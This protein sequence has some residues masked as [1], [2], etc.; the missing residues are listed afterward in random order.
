[1]K[2]LFF[3]I[4]LLMASVAVFG[5]KQKPPQV[6]KSKVLLD[7]GQIDE[8]KTIID[9]AIIFEKTKDKS[10]TWY[11][12]GLIYESIALRQ[13]S[14]G[15]NRDPMAFN[16][17]IEGFSKV[18]TI[19]NQFGTFFLFSDQRL[20]NLYAYLF[21][22]AAQSYQNEEFEDAVKYFD[23]VKLIY[24]DDTLAYEYAGYAAQQ[25]DNQDIALRNFEYMADHNMASVNVHRN[26]IYIY[27]SL[28]NDTTAALKATEKA[29]QQ[30]PDDHDLKQ[31]EISMLIMTNQE[32]KAKKQLE[33]AISK[34]PDNHIYYYELGY[35]YDVSDDYENSVRYYEMSLEKNPDF[36][37]ANFNLAVK[38][39]NEGAEIEKEAQ[40]MSV[41]E[42]RK[43]GKEVEE[44]A[45]VF[46]KKSLP[47]FE[48]CHELEPG[49]VGVL[50]TLQTLY[51]FLKMPEKAEQARQK[52]EALG[53]GDY[54]DN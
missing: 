22:R 33:D 41:E 23:F 35:I 46:F 18:K 17:A 5:Q 54:N 3:I 29:R 44:K 10:K 6:E 11:Y 49:Q 2:N 24:P 12:Y 48:K 4:L 39:Y 42:Y 14:L 32:E 27:R 45:S 25:F 9:E 28:K 37:D 34:D 31:E 19:E 20:N 50:Q 30:F 47:Y 38:H 7:K 53:G 13:D 36:F 26:I 15:E 52:V 43:R 8:A 1:M 51:A 40:F 16:K 21:N